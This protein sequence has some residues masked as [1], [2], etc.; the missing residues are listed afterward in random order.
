MEDGI[1]TRKG[2][3]PIVHS[4]LPISPLPFFG[5][6]SLTASQPVISQLV[7]VVCLSGPRLALHPYPSRTDFH[8]APVGDIHF[9]LLLYHNATQL[10]KRLTDIFLIYSVFIIPQYNTLNSLHSIINTLS[11]YTKF[12]SGKIIAIPTLY[13][14][15]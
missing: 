12:F 7:W 5:R 1:R 13:Y 11:A 15:K 14:C 10:V 9:V 2:F 3:L 8:G 4:R 6:S